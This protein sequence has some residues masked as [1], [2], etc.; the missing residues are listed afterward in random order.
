MDREGFIL[1][2]FESRLFDA[3]KQFVGW[4]VGAVMRSRGHEIVGRSR[5]PGGLFTVGAIWSGEPIVNPEM[6]QAA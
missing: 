1:A 6:S 3:A 2:E 4:A 5:V